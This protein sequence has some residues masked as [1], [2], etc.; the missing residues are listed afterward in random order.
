MKSPR[1]LLLSLFLLVFACGDEDP[2]RIQLTPEQRDA[3]HAIALARIDSL[4]PILDSLCSATFEDRVAIATDSIVQRRLEEEAR[5][6]SRIPQ[7]SRQ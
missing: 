5:L 3:Y 7:I 2:L 1:P 4:R 6:R